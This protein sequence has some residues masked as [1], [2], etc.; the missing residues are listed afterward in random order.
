MAKSLT[1]PSKVLDKFKWFE[2]TGYHP[3]AGQTAIHRSRARHKVLSNGRRWGKTLLGG[4][5]VEPTAF[6][7]NWMGLSQ[8]GW[9]VGPN[10]TDCEKEFRVVYDTFKALGVDT[11]S[12]KFL[13]NVDNGNMVIHTRW[14]FHLE[15]RSAAHPETLV[16]E[17]LDFVLMV[18][19]GRQK[20]KTWTEYIRPALS[21]KRGWSLHSGVPEGATETSL[22]YF[23]YQ[24]GQ[25]AYVLRDGVKRPNP[26]AS[27]RMPSWTNTIT[28]PGG[29]KDPEILDTEDDL[30]EEEFRRQYGAEFVDRIGRVM[31]EWDDDLHIHDL[32]FNPDW[33]LYMGVDYGYTNP[34]VVL[35]IQ[36]DHLNNVYVIREDR[37]TLKDTEDVAKEI[38][39]N[40][41]TRAL[42]RHLVAF[43]PDPAEPDDTE[44]LKKKWR[45]PARS[46]T[47]GEI[48][49][50]VS[51]IRSALKEYNTHLA[52]SHPDR[53][54]KLV[55]DRSCKQLI[56]EMREG[57]RWPEHKSDVKNESE[58]PMDKD[59]HG[60]EALGRFFKGFMDVV[61]ES[62]RTRQRTAKVHR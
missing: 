47:G 62:R 38:L 25:A 12:D 11:V 43:Y 14:G 46:N 42:L 16:G 41:V 54:A 45:K 28:F 10:Y 24:R 20:R 19:A 4:K 23:L 50:R 29:R 15:C 58:N 61:G 48:K 6:V 52:P 44:T 1:V 27:W 3:H 8:I 51:L 9:I 2:Q 55:V 13:K 36:V 60:P 35:W 32:E 7:K 21:D 17:G 18:E 31:K 49:N 40:P 56:W 59:N 33:P 57:Y 53:R 26:W 30:T 22:L 5:E 37:F 34:F 39:D